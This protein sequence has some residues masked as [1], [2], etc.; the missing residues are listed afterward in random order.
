MKQ[1]LTRLTYASLTVLGV[2][3]LQL[4]AT[5]SAE[6]AALQL[7]GKITRQASA[8]TTGSGQQSYWFKSSDLKYTP[9]NKP[10]RQGAEMQLFCLDHD[11]TSPVSTVGGTS[12]SIKYEIFDKS[13]HTVAKSNVFESYNNPKK[14]LAIFNY[15]F[16]NYYYTYFAGQSAAKQR[17]WQMLLW[18]V[19]EDYNG[20]ASSISSSNG[21]VTSQL[22]GFSGTNYASELFGKLKAALYAN[23]IPDNYK[24]KNKFDINLLH[25]VDSGRTQ[26]QD[27]VVYAIAPIPA[28]LPLFGSALL[29]VG[30]LALRRRRNAGA[31]AAA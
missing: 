10:Y 5:T 26:T 17:A 9:G 15:I 20:S 3:A 13:I 4:P 8:N 22:Y 28:A 30:G 31:M 29:G 19:A 7:T 2:L 18:E 11:L 24:S 27:M 21:V 1:K 14:G 23:L 25:V 6:A 12:S 16:D